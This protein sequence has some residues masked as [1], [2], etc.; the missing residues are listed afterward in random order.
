MTSTTPAHQDDPKLVELPKLRVTGPA[1]LLAAV[2]YLI[3]FHPAESLV[4]VGIDAARVVVTARL[5]LA[6][7]ADIRGFIDDTLTTLRNG[8]ASLV[9]AVVYDDSQ[10]PQPRLLD[11]LVLAASLADCELLDVL[12]VASGQWWSLTCEDDT[13]CPPE[14]RPLGD[15]RLAAEATFAGLSA[16]PDR[17]T[18]HATLHPD[19][20]REALRPQLRDARGSHELDAIVAE[21]TAAHDA[22]RNETSQALA[23]TVLTV[24]QV[25]RFGVALRE[26]DVRDRIWVYIDAQQRRSE[27]LWR[28]LAR[29]LPPPYDVAPLFLLGWS[30]FRSGNGALANIACERCLLSDADYGAAKLLLSAL[31]RGVDPRQLPALQIPA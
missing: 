20:E 17:A 16:L 19:P 2:P 3:G 31:S 6:D 21:I 18:L 4:L 22:L 15:S 9:L 24:E 11:E 10:R 27:V 30:A 1:E 28:E 26:I 8:G 5:D 13:C 14:G 29:R 7:A 25:V 12:Y 23:T